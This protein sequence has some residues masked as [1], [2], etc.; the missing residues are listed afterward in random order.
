MLP[1]LHTLERIIEI[2]IWRS[3]RVLWLVN[4]V[5]FLYKFHPFGY[6]LLLKRRMKEINSSVFILSICLVFLLLNL[7]KCIQSKLLKNKIVASLR[8]LGKIRLWFIFFH[9]TWNHEIS[10]VLLLS[11]LL[12]R[13]GNREINIRGYKLISFIVFVQREVLSV[14]VWF[15]EVINKRLY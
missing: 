11:D 15:G 2:E 10:T 1:H 5:T 6:I 9:V 3:L 7:K 4:I 8:H 13:G 12:N 14:F